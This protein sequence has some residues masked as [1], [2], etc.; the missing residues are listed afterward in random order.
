MPAQQRDLGPA[1][2]AR[3]VR[4]KLRVEVGGGG[5]EDA[6]DLVGVEVIELSQLL[7][8]V[9][10]GLVD[11]LRRVLASGGRAAD[12]PYRHAFKS[13]LISDTPSP[14]R[15]TSSTIALPT[16]AASSFPRSA[17][18]WSWREM[19]KPAATGSVVRFLSSPSSSAMPSGRSLRMPVIPVTVTQ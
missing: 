1:Q 2:P 19:P 11:G 6:G 8:Q 15:S 9:G 10:G 5:E 18:R 12:S 14:A 7:Q 13:S 4:G 3:G 16:T 17:L